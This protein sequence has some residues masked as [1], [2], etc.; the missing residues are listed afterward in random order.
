MS[1]EPLAH[2]SQGYHRF[3]R[4]APRMLRALDIKAA[5]VAEP[6]MVAVNIIQENR[7]VTEK[8]ITFLRRASKWFR[9]LKAQDSD[10]DRLWE[11]AVMSHL[12]DAFRSGDIWLAHSRRYG[13]LKQALVPIEAAKVTPR[14]TVPF[15]PEEWLKPRTRMIISSFRACHAGI[16]KVMP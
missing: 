10:Y 11:V 5:S 9:H 16:L 1:A 15:D 8:P 2:V 12:R 7:D 13:D 3:R 4:Y 6:L 14:L